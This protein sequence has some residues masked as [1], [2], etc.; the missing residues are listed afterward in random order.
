MRIPKITP[1]LTGAVFFI[2]LMTGGRA[3]AVPLTISEVIARLDS[4]SPAL[5][6]ARVKL[7]AARSAHTSSRAFPNPA[8]FMDGQSLRAHDESEAEQAIGVQ[9][10][11]GFLWAAPSNIASKKLAFEAEQAAYDEKRRE[12]MMRVVSLVDRYHSLEQ[13]NALMDTVLLTA[14]RAQE[15]M[16]ARRREGDVSDYDSKRLYAELIQLQLRR[17]QLREEMNR[18]AADFVE[19]TGQSPDILHEVTVPQL[20]PPFTATV[21]DAIRLALNER[22]ALQARSMSLA[23]SRKAYVSAKMN[24]LPDFS[25][26]IGRKSADPELSGWVWQAELEIPLWGQRRSERN[27]ARV[28]Q[29]QEA[30][31]YQA[32]LQQVEQEVRAAFAEWTLICETITLP[33]PFS[34]QDAEISLNRGVELFAGGEFSSVEL[35]DALR[36]SLDALAAHLDLQSALLT[37]NL[38][39]RYVTGLPILE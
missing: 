27:L 16:I 7:A 1:L 31:L 21:E 34:R 18:G 17:I 32:A 10:P 8:L 23:A 20:P 5:A 38:K 6:E 26:G 28:E 29:E 25:V 33:H 37:A 12:L 9:Q 36:S 15:S 14:Q 35:V 19:T 30:I 11:L 13:Q 4:T 3:M 22:P 39:L 2:L 24:Q